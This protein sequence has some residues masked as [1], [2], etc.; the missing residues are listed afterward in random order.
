MEWVRQRKA[1]KDEVMGVASI[2]DGLSVENTLST[3]YY[4]N[5]ASF[6]G[7]FVKSVLSFDLEKIP[8]DLLPGR[9]WCQV[10]VKTLDEYSYSLAGRSNSE[11]V[12]PEREDYLSSP[13]LALYPPCVEDGGEGGA[14]YQPDFRCVQ[15][16]KD[17]RTWPKDEGDERD[18]GNSAEDPSPMAKEDTDMSIWPRGE[19][20]SADDPSLVDK[21]TSAWPRDER[22]SADD[23]S[24][25]A[26]ARAASSTR[27][28]AAAVGCNL[29]I[30]FFI[31]ILLVSHFGNTSKGGE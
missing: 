10:L 9:Y 16:E 12:I 28:V 2:L 30:A 23:L 8:G 4:D 3:Y 24:T 1:S 13:E 21:D 5:S 6:V 20:D 25:V 29:I 15:G 11:T 18:E 26:M 14:F 31:L 22:D 7:T 17:T 19:G 27:W